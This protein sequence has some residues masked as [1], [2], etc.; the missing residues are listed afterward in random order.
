MGEVRF[1]FLLSA[2][3][4]A[5]PARALAVRAGRG[6]RGGGW[7]LMGIA[8]FIL[9]VAWVVFFVAMGYWF[10]RIDS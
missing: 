5:T 3:Q 8:V 2:V 7:A 4:V 9:L 6:L 1:H 10:A